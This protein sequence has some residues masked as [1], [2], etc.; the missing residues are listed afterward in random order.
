[1][2]DLTLIY[3]VYLLQL[4]F[5]IYIANFGRAYSVQILKNAEFLLC[6]VVYATVF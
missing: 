2:I 6:Q 5:L 4:Q 3:V 1:M